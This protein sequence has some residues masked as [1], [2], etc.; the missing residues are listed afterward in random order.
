MSKPTCR[1]CG[2]TIKDSDFAL[3]SKKGHVCSACLVRLVPGNPGPGPDAARLGLPAS[4]RR[5]AAVG[6]AMSL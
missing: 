6:L 2:K 5:R 1:L 4:A 3:S